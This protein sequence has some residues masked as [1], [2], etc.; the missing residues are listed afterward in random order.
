MNRYRDG[1]IEPDT[2]QDQSTHPGLVPLEEAG[3]RA[4]EE[5]GGK[6][7]TLGRLLRAGFP[8]P[9][10]FV[11]TTEALSPPPE[12]PGTDASEH[13]E[14]SSP[15]SPAVARKL[16]AAAARLGGARLAV[17]SSG[18]SEDGTHASYAGQFRTELDVEGGEELKVAIRRCWTA[19]S[20]ERVRAYRSARDGQGSASGPRL[21]LLVQ[22]MVPAEASGVAFTADPRDGARNAV[23]VEAVSGVGEELVSGKR[24]P[25]RWRMFEGDVER[26]GGPDR[27][28]EPSTAAEVGRLARRAEEVLG[29]PQDVEWAVHDGEVHLLQARPITAGAEVTS[30]PVPVDPPG[31]GFWFRDEA[32][33]PRPF[34][35]LF[36][37]LYVPRYEEAVARAFR[38]FG[39]LVDGLEIREIGGWPY[40]R[41]VPPAG[42]EG[43]APPPWLLWI[44]ARLAP[45]L[46]AKMSRA[47]EARDEDREMIYV[48]RWWNEWRPELDRWIRRAD[49]VDLAS[50][51]REELRAHFQEA[52]ETFD[53]SL[54][55]HFKLFP[56]FFL[57]VTDLVFFCR[58]EMGW[59]KSRAT[60]L[61]GGVSEMSSEPGRALEKLARAGAEDPSV[62]AVLD[63]PA[64]APVE[65]LRRKAPEFAR[66]FRE[67]QE[68]YGLRVLHYDF[69]TPTFRERPEMV[70]GLVRN[71]IQRGGDAGPGPEDAGGLREERIGE[72]RRRLRDRPDARKRFDTLLKRAHRAYPVREDN[73][74]FALS[75][76]G[77]LRFAALE[78]GR[79][80]AAAGHLDRA[81][82]VFFLEGVEVTR[83]LEEPRDVGPVARRREGERRWAL[84]N[85][86]PQTYGEDPGPPPDPSPLPPAG[87][88]TMRAL[89]WTVEN[90][91]QTPP[92]ES[93]GLEGV[94]ASPGSYTGPVRVVR[95]E[96]EFGKV[97]AGDVLVCPITSPTWSVLFPSL[98]ALVTDAGGLLSHPAIIAREFAI[99]AVLATGRATEE[100]SDGE[101][102][103]VDGSAG[104]VER[105]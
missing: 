18:V 4:I 37:S 57:T 62:R 7:H 94:A 97:R 46:R 31:T 45:P 82:Q 88:R 70:L 87:R 15:L 21:A 64:D 79:R 63:G 33:F 104:R 35:P 101:M 96:E 8:V 1:A 3:D 23:V 30:V 102:V 73:E 19:G 76:L 68:R 75:V 98:G 29:G 60:E 99:P 39:V 14:G 83:W 25:E 84:A 12:P 85:P 36:S 52:V 81:D 53:R 66:A 13:A 20:S 90:D 42:K 71:R 48:R 100:L 69:G 47:R 65:R 93:E 61:L 58:D 9:D 92:P 22:R 28:L 67:Y 34:H 103:T 16:E 11:L 51:T 44:L 89:L 78:V 95:S 40:S 32:H 26:E 24:T 56:P 74:F 2:D 38:D 41:I 77:L 91:I 59:E 50:L 80:M 5:V 105:R 55:I 10:G 43:P 6:A 27:V 86:G 17:R 49:A 54:R 72:A